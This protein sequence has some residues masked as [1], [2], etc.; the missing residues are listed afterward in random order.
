ML[1]EI[2]YPAVNRNLKIIFE[3]KFPH[4]IIGWEETYKDGW[5]ENAPLLTTKATLKKSILSDYW[6]K[7][8]VADTT[9]RKTLE[10]ER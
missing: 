3:K 9:W 1:Y 4:K 6:T 2:K 8:K 5:G 10:I 7:N